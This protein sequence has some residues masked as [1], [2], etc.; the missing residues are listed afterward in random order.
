[1]PMSPRPDAWKTACARAKL[2]KTPIEVALAW[3]SAG[4]AVCPA[5][6]R[7]FNEDGSENGSYK[8]KL[9]T[10]S[11][12][13]ATDAEV[14]RLWA[15]SKWPDSLVWL[16]G[17]K[18]N[19]FFCL[20]VDTKEAHGHDGLAEWA[21]L[22]DEFGDADTR[23]HKTPSGGQHRIYLQDAERPVGGGR[24]HIPKGIDVKGEGQGI[25][26]PGSLPGYEVD[27]DL[28]PANPPP[29]LLD[30][31]HGG[32]AKKA[33]AKKA[34]RKKW[35][36]G[37]GERKLVKACEVIGSAAP[38]SRD[39]TSKKA[40]YIGSL[41]A[42]GAIDQ[43]HARER[44]WNAALGCAGPSY[45]EKVARHFDYGLGSAAEPPAAG[46]V[47]EDGYFLNRSGARVGD[48]ANMAHALRTMPELAGLFRF[49]QFA[50]KVLLTRGVPNLHEWTSGETYPTPLTDNHEFQLVEYL[51][52]QDFASMTP[53]AG[54]API[55]QVAFENSFH[56]VKDYLEKV[57]WDG[58]SRVNSWLSVYLGA[59]AGTYA[60]KIGTMFLVSM[61][62]RIYR[63][64]CQA[65]YV[66]TLEGSQ[67]LMKSTALRNLVGEQWFSDDLPDIHDKDAK[68]HLRGKWL[69]E[70]GELARM[71][72]A[73]LLTYKA[74]ITRRADKFRPAYG[75]NEVDVSRANVFAATTNQDQY[76][77]DDTG[78]RR[79][80]P[81]L[82]GVIDLKGLERDRDQL[83]AEAKVM[84]GEGV[85]WWPDRAFEAEFI[86]PEQHERVIMDSLD[87]AVADALLSLDGPVTQS[88]L[89]R[90]MWPE[91]VCSATEHRA[92]SHKLGSAMR[93]A[94]WE[95]MRRAKVE[96]RPTRR[97]ERGD[98]AEPKPATA[99]D[100]VKPKAE[101]S[102]LRLV[103][104]RNRDTDTPF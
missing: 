41:A 32:K 14:R 37:F 84:F 97:W 92:L 85:Q 42:G 88:D 59:E 18:R 40:I 96:G 34:G 76:L 71:Q 65:D 46:G 102:E 64:G 24:G 101:Q 77:A 62:A 58:T 27:Q 26:A 47:D 20:D 103:G 33:K 78:N 90:A 66:L 98:K 21:K 23:T 39:E 87:E 63:P 73:E 5:E 82:C 79:T 12:V 1:M 53:G 75:R 69:I 86:A 22:V 29:W 52:H 8:G 4:F 72:R 6:H 16:P 100:V 93:K 28:N 7:P 31:L 104:G 38:G 17:G 50:D 30:I 95:P 57:T 43:A 60:E 44:L 25:I 99:G 19:G 2:A 11:D 9:T 68:G 91:K 56:P 81:I 15:K 67:G 49:D 74:F 35:P 36:E 45:A 83:W 48:A 61:V 54:H 10:G 13:A 80:W 94:G 51:R 70:I 3:V 55:L 89:L